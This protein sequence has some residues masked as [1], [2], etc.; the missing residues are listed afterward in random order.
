MKLDSVYL[1]FLLSFGIYF[2]KKM[3]LNFIFLKNHV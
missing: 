2:G 1:E 3:I